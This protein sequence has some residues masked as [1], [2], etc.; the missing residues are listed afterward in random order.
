MNTFTE[1]LRL[2]EEAKANKLDLT[3][4][5]PYGGGYEGSPVLN[6]PDEFVGRDSQAQAEKCGLAMCPH[7]LTVGS[8]LTDKKRT[9]QTLK[10][11]DKKS[12]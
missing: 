11:S 9:N 8:M 7:D 5:R 12:K 2:R 6:D 3:Y 1:W 4:K 10:N